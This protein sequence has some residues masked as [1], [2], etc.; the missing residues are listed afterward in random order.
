MGNI[1]VIAGPII[2]HNYPAI[3]A[4][5][6][7]VEKYFEEK[8][9]KGKV[10]ITTGGLITEKKGKLVMELLTS[11]GLIIDRKTVNDLIMEH[12]RKAF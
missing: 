4:N 8:S 12:I 6:Y 5:L 2:E 1:D 11:G 7:L 3:Y 9:N 10:R